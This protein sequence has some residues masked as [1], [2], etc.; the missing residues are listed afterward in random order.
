MSRLS[1]RVFELPLYDDIEESVRKVLLLCDD[2]PV[3]AVRA[4]ILGQ[5]SLMEAYAGSVST[6]YVRRKG[7]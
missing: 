3:V 4:L 6:G 7:L 5:R 2:D 1:E